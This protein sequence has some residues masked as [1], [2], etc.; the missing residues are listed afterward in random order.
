VPFDFTD[1]SGTKWRPA[2]VVSSDRYHGLSPDVL[3]APITGNLR[4][5]PHPGDHPLR[6]WQAAGLIKPSLLQAKL[7]TV[8]ASTLGRRLGHLSAHDLAAFD[9]GLSDALGLRMIDST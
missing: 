4:A 7:A 5:L 1:R 8:E 2:A 9:R 3:I 6:D